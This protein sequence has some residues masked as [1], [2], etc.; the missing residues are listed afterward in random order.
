MI[1][2]QVS[3]HKDIIKQI[4]SLKPKCVSLSIEDIENIKAH[5]K[6]HQSNKMTM[7]KFR[8]SKAELDYALKVGLTF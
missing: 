2:N 5:H 7:R 3:E 1:N 8:I 4:R 6:C